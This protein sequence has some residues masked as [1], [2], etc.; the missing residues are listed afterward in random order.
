MF[1]GTFAIQILLQ[2]PPS[3]LLPNLLWQPYSC[4][5]LGE[6]HSSFSLPLRQLRDV[7]RVRKQKKNTRKAD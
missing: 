6:V 4:K 5:L 3:P 1:L 2:L 7:T